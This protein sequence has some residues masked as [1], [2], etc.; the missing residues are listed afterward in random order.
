M[1][2]FA[3]MLHL[4]VGLI[5][6]AV[7]TVVGFFLYVPLLARQIAVYSLVL[8][9]ASLGKGKIDRAQA[10]LEKAIE[11]Y[12]RG[13]SLA[14]RVITDSHEEREHYDLRSPSHVGLFQLIVELAWSAL[15]WGWLALTL[16]RREWAYQLIDFWRHSRQTLGG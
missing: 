2:V 7:W 14:W 4:A 3:F 6:L 9:A 15:F 16:G 10:S 13:F 12:P 11:F 8:S 5:V 1:K